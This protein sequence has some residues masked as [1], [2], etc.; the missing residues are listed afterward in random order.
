MTIIGCTLSI[1][2]QRAIVNSRT[3]L[4]VSAEPDATKMESEWQ[5]WNPS[6][7]Q[8]HLANFSGIIVD[9][10]ID[11]VSDTWPQFIIG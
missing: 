11:E 9:P 10:Q 8:S 6:M 2:D 4:I 5:I 1:I 7:G 3:K